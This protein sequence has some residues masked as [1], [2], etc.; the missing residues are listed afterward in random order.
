MIVRIKKIIAALLAMLLLSGFFTKISALDSVT[1]EENERIAIER[2]ILG[3]E[4]YAESIDLSD[5]NIPVSSL[6]MLFSHATKNTPYLFYVDKRLTYTYRGDTVFEVIP[7]Y[8]MTR[9]EANSAIKFCREE[10]EKMAGVVHK[11]DG[12]LERLILAH[13]LICSRF[14]YDLSLENNDIYKFIKERKGTCQGYTWTYM[15]LLREL[16]IE[17]EYVASDNIEHI[18]LRVKIDGEWYNTDATWDDPIGEQDC[19]TSVSRLHLLFS[20]IKAESDGYVERY[21]ASNNKCIS[22]KYDGDDLS[23]IVSQNHTA[24][25]H[26]H[27]GCVNL[28]D[29]AMLLQNRGACPLCADV[30]LDFLMTENDI[31]KLRELILTNVS[32]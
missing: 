9:D 12:E 16:G 28:M 4:S 29:L 2:M 10:I 23:N 13:D 31:D 8:N 18:W 26:N 6:S 7:K 3:F 11:E 5:L 22:T 14:K 32:G 27:D 25:D 24:G 30:D 1:K 19:S 20:D 21:G 17:C 15:A